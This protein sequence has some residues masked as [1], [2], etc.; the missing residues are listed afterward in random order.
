MLETKRFRSKA[1]IIVYKKIK[2]NR[3]ES[4][5]LKLQIFQMEE[6]FP[7]FLIVS[8]NFRSEMPKDRRIKIT[9]SFSSA[10]ELSFL[11]HSHRLLD[12]V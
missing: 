3:K 8:R 4:T 1:E 7:T 6:S 9:N 2:L 10:S 12:S 11:I 5:I